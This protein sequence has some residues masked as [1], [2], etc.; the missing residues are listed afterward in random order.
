MIL[1]VVYYLNLISLHVLLAVWLMLTVILYLYIK[2]K[3][4]CKVKSFFFETRSL[5]FDI[6]LAILLAVHS[7][8]LQIISRQKI[9]IIKDKENV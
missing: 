9:L 4:V 3:K 8:G 5:E 1:N 2:Q 6:Y 7:H